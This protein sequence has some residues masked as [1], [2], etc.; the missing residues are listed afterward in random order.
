MSKPYND[1]RTWRRP[2]TFLPRAWRLTEIEEATLDVLCGRA[3]RRLKVE[4]NFLKYAQSAPVGPEA[5][6]R[7]A[8]VR[9]TIG[10]L[11]SVRQR[12]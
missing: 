7:L 5:S 12:R 9:E 2:L 3:S 8:V 4:A 11:D 6:D 1:G 10:I